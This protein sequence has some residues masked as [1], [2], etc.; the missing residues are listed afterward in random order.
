MKNTGAQAEGAGPVPGGLNEQ[1][2]L[3]LSLAG[4]R[5]V[6]ES[7][8]LLTAEVDFLRAVLEQLP[9]QIFVKDA[10]S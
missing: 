4:A 1:T 8:E 5:I 2:R 6:S 3:L 10:Q 7:T 9:A